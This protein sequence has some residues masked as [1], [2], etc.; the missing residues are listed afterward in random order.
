M[1]LRA[2]VLGG[3][4][5]A[6]TAAVRSQQMS[7][8]NFRPE[9]PKTWDTAAVASMSIPLAPPA[10][11]VTEFSEQYYYSIPAVTIYKSYPLVSA[12]KPFP[13]YLNWLK[14]QEPEIAFD[15][16]KLKTK[17]DWEEAGELVFA[18]ALGGYGPIPQ[19]Y[20]DAAA[21]P[22]RGAALATTRVFIREKG[23]LE[24]NIG[25]GPLGSVRSCA[26]CH[27]QAAANGGRRDGVQLSGGSI[28]PSPGIGT[29]SATAEERRQSMLFWYGT[30]WFNPD[31]N[32]D[33]NLTSAIVRPWN[34]APAAD[35]REG[36]SLRSPVQI[37]VLIGLKDRKYFDHTGLHLHR[38]IGDLMRYAVLASGLDV[39]QGYGDFIP[40]GRN[41]HKDLPPPSERLRFTD[42]QLY[43]LALYIYSL[44]YPANPNR[45][46]SVSAN[47]EK[48]F[49]REGC[50]GCHTPPLYTNNKLIPVD[51]F[52]VP[53]EDRKK[54]DILDVRIGLDPYLAMKT[55]RGTGYYKVPSLRGVWMRSA[56]EHNASV[57][58][59]E[60]WFDPNRLK[61]A[62]VPTGF[63]GQDPTRAVKGHPFGLQ[64]SPD[65]K[66]ALIAYLRTL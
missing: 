65:D 64:L 29:R 16:S 60:D 22:A 54:Y 63:R 23:K 40:G 8:A 57:A 37:P 21:D 20:L 35:D 41:D 27:S 24:R 45:P 13:E 25:G 14:Q 58:S 10:P 53:P 1:L 51:G 15:A 39:L 61:E 49:N 48:I 31:P 18:F 3:A 17:T 66:K 56:L 33:V 47:G 32:V 28:Y 30:P 5:L 19:L 44:D 42:E 55:R 50:A 46:D 11:R 38:S 2:C 6:A 26:S 34:A 7:N 36:T 12:D 4:I 43:A 52:V 62:Y 9:I 59:L